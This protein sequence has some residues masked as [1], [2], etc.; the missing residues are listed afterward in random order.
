MKIRFL[1]FIAFLLFLS[2][3]KKNDVLYID[4]FENYTTDKTPGG[5]WKKTGKG[6]AV[7]DDTK[8]YSG[9]K[10]VHFVTG[11]GYQ[12]R[13]FLELDHIFPIKDNAYYGSVK[14]YIEE[15]S[16]DGIHWTMVQSSGKVKDA[17][18]SS[19]IRYG[20]QHNKK[21]MANYETQGVQSDC[22]KHAQTKIPEGTWFTLQWY[23]NGNE[24]TMQL[25]LDGTVIESLC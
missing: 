21:L 4:N 2:C 12:N 14:M 19:E 11:E 5:P 25:W 15:A 6:T 1:V 16:P 18:Y 22:W 23:F 24:D 3:H 8:S 7:I 20:G 17:A 9:S 13:A 10:S